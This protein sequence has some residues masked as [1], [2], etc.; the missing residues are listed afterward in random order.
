MSPQLPKNIRHLPKSEHLIEKRFHGLFSEK[1]T[2]GGT[3]GGFVSQTQLR[4]LSLASENIFDEITRITWKT[5][6]NLETWS[7]LNTRRWKRLRN[8]DLTHGYTL[9]QTATA[10]IGTLQIPTS[11]LQRTEA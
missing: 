3:P 11:R 7:F 6:Q 4:Q 9:Q 8:W 1:E 2:S 10:Y 5:K